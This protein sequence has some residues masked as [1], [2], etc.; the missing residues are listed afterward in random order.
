MKTR[1]AVSFAALL[2]AAAF[3]GAYAASRGVASTSEPAAREPAPVADAARDAAAEPDPFQTPFPNKSCP[4]L[5]TGGTKCCLWQVF[6]MGEGERAAKFGDPYKCET[7][8][9]MPGDMTMKVPFHSGGAECDPMAKLIPDGSVLEAKG[10]VIRRGDGFGPFSGEFNILDPTGK[11]LFTGCIETLDRVGTHTSCDK[12]E[13]DSHYE[14]F[15][16]GRG[17]GALSNVSIR[18]SIAARGML[19][20]PTMPKAATA[21][22]INGTLI[23]CP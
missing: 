12:C 10:R 3:C 6:K 18:A 16:T 15:M 11:T 8:A 14:G 13:P 7:G 22:V 9:T 5:P 20:S 19:P 17:V 23:R 21:I 2:V 4:D 1:Y